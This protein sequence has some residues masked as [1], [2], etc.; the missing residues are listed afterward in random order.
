MTAHSPARRPPALARPVRLDGP[1]GRYARLLRAALDGPLRLGVINR[2]I[3]LRGPDHASRDEKRAS[4]IAATVLTRAG[5]LTWTPAGLTTTAAG[6]AALAAVDGG[7][8][9][10]RTAASPLSPS[11]SPSPERT[12]P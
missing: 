6:R 12:A 4:W 7:P 11:P 10:A 8:G 2:A 1:H 5:L 3:R 9:A